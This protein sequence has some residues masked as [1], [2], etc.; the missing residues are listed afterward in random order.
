MISA[1]KWFKIFGSGCQLLLAHCDV[2][3]SSS[4]SFAPTYPVDG[5][6]APGHHSP[7]PTPSAT[8]NLGFTYWL[9]SD[10]T[11]QYLSCSR[12]LPRWIEVPVPPTIIHAASN[13]SWQSVPKGQISCRSVIQL[14]NYDGRLSSRWEKLIKDIQQIKYFVSSSFSFFY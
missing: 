2:I 5:R 13:S 9:T 10:K 1:S 11:K 14:T 3:M 12:P 4:F 7:G 8:T 6:R